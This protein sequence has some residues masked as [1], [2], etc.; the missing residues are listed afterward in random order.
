MKRLREVNSESSLSATLTLSVCQKTADSISSI[1]ALLR[2]FLRLKNEIAQVFLEMV[3]IYLKFESSIRGFSTIQDDSRV[4]SQSLLKVFGSQSELIGMPPFTFVSNTN[5]VDS[6]EKYY[7]S[8]R[9]VIESAR[10]QIVPELTKQLPALDSLI[11]TELLLRCITRNSLQKEK[12][13]Q[14]FIDKDRL[15]RIVQRHGKDAVIDCL[16]RLILKNEII[17]PYKNLTMKHPVACFQSL[18]SHQTTFTEAP[19][20]I[21]GSFN[22]NCDFEINAL[23]LHFPTGSFFPFKYKG[24]YLSIVSTDEDY[25]NIDIITEFFQ[26]QQRVQAR[27]RDMQQSPLEFWSSPNN[28]SVLEFVIS[29]NQDV[30]TYNL[31]EA[32]FSSIKECTQ[33]KCSLVRSIISLFNARSMLDFSAGWGDRLIGALGSSCLSTYVGVDPNLDLKPGHDSI[34]E[35]LLPIREKVFGSNGKF[36]I[37]YEPFQHCALPANQSYDLVFTSPPYFDFEIYTESV[38]GQ[39]ILDFPFFE[40]WVV[41]FLFASLKKAWTNLNDC[42]HLVIHLTDIHGAKVCELM[43]LYIQSYLPGAIYVG[44][45]ASVGSSCETSRPMWVWYKKNFLLD[46]DKLRV[47]Q[48]RKH[49]ADYYPHFATKLS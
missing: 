2:P 48:G 44:L 28:K 35:K 31:R 10:S 46:S 18:L 43:N 39:S 49:L 27:R 20:A 3:M 5:S 16:S 41:G 1:L 7:A 30:T 26:E 42:G 14:I 32:L 36:R 40:D 37:I 23:G 8:C 34:I 13:G 25:H 47:N 11:L 29:K 4:D 21:K 24:N 17:F 33:F 15:N 22:C 19:Y 9:S 12:N 6:W 38:Q 45:L